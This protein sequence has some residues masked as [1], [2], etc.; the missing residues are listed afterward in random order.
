MLSRNTFPSW[1]C[2]SGMVEFRGRHSQFRRISTHLNYQ[3]TGST[4]IWTLKSE[5]MGLEMDRSFGW[6]NSHNEQSRYPHFPPR[7]N[8]QQFAPS[9][10]HLNRVVLPKNP[11]LFCNTAKHSCLHVSCVFFV[12]V[13]EMIVTFTGATAGTSVFS[14]WGVFKDQYSIPVPFSTCMF[15]IWKSCLY[16]SEDQLMT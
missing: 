13:F 3:Q 2:T 16:C 8:L 14:N 10:S 1:W 6:S 12:A 11:F 7:V 5:K 4:P 9:T 15:R